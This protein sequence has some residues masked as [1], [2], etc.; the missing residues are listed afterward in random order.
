MA[1]QSALVPGVKSASIFNTSIRFFLLPKKL[2]S[3]GAA[4]KTTKEFTPP[5]YCFRMSQCNRSLMGQLSVQESHN[6][7]SDNSYQ[8]ESHV[9]AK[10]GEQRS[11]CSE[12]HAAML[13]SL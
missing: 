9:C 13:G 4:L 2:T 6:S 10:R 3:P 7:Q 11:L 1:S 12:K 5:I 8:C